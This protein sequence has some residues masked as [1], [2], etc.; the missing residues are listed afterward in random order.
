ARGRRRKD[1]PV[2]PQKHVPTV[3]RHAA[4]PTQRLARLLL[5]AVAVSVLGLLPGVKGL[6]PAGPA[7]VQAAPA[8]QP[9]AV[10]PTSG[11]ADTAP[12]TGR[13]R[14]RDLLDDAVASTGA[15]DEHLDVT[16]A[17]DQGARFFL[18]QAHARDS[19]DGQADYYLAGPRGVSHQPLR[20]LFAPLGTW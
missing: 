2:P 10:A 18:L 12:P 19:D 7:V 3:G 13:G 17:L 6:P 8:H 20:E 16:A 1:H 15:T 9:D 11:T 4:A 14:T 5:V